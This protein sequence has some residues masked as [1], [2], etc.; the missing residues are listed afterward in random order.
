MHRSM[1][2]RQ[3]LSQG[4]AWV[5]LLA[6]GAWRA[7]PAW[8]ASFSSADATAALRTA[9]DRCADIAV[10]Q[11]GASNGFLSNDKVHIGLPPLLEKASPVLRA[12]GRGRQL[13]E[14]TTAMNHAA[15]QAVSQAKPLLVTAIKDMSVDDATKILKGGDNSVTDY[16]SAKTRTP[17][18]A[19]FKPVMDKAFDKQPIAK[20]YTDV[21][22][23]AAKLRLP[24]DAGDTLQ[25]HVT[26]RA[27]DGLYFVIGEEERRIR[28][29]PVGTGSALLK[30]VF[31]GL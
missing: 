11:L 21:A 18:S 2:R 23:K 19:S 9:L 29:D 31:G 10:Q 12:M 30:K 22:R 8:S 1:N 17:L 14:L 7:Q 25:D 4:S 27:L 13:D 5:T 28:R 20:L 3:L 24:V 15:E 26:Q 6:I 16:F